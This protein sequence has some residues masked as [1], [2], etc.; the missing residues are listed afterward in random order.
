MNASSLYLFGKD[1]LAPAIKL[2]SDHTVAF[3]FDLVVAEIEKV[4]AG[5]AAENENPSTPKKILRIA[6]HNLASPYW[7]EIKGNVSDEF[8]ARN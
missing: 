5:H 1:T 4:I 3:K 6:I 8:N 7:G 2:S